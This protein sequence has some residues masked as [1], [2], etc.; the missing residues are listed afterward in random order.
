MRRRNGESSHVKG[1][2]ACSCCDGDKLSPLLVAT[3]SVENAVFSQN[4][5]NNA[6]K[7]DVDD[8][9]APQL[10]F[11][12]LSNPKIHSSNHPKISSSEKRLK[13]SEC[14]EKLQLCC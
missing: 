8:R 3:S 12:E 9:P 10:K 6:A 14:N 7:D 4:A 5:G 13:H 11:S 1:K 2:P